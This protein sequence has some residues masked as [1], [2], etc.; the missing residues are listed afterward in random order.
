[1]ITM[2]FVDANIILA[3][4]NEADVHHAKAVKIVQSIE[5]G[6]YG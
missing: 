2:I 6:I 3:N 4:D 5:G 1:M